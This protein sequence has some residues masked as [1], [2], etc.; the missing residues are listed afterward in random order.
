[1]HRPIS[2]FRCK[3][4]LT[5]EL[6]AALA[7][8]IL[9]V[10]AHA[11][12]RA[13]T[14]LVVLHASVTDKRGKLLTNLNRDAF[15]VYENGQLQ[16]VK[17][18]RREDVPVSL[19]III[20]DSGSM[21]TKRARVEAASLAMVR[22]SNPQDEVFI[23][24]FNDEPFLDVPFTNDI[25]KLEQGLARIDSRGGTAM[26]DAI[27]SSLDYMKQKAKKDK[28]VLMVITDG[29]DNA[30]NIS[31]EKVVARSNQSDTLVYAIGLFTEEERHEATKARRALNELTGATGGLAFYPK[32]VAEVQSLAVEVAHDIRSQ[33][34]IAYSPSIQQ[35]D[36]SYRQIKVTVSAPGKPVV[37]TRSGYYATPDVERSKQVNANAT[38]TV[39]SVPQP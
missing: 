22:E 17:V 27:S 9:P 26:R 15:K 35:L 34:T 4:V 21:A 36:G 29:N 14:R 7:I 38:T 25:H 31:L 3:T 24:N 10:C 12:F 11:Q 8:C 33:Y 2:S 23:V 39:A 28:K 5:R 16:Q 30:S 1:M 32:E 37:R 19:G 13:D 6:L 18:F 20:D